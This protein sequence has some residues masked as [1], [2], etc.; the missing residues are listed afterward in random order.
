MVHSP[1]LLV[2]GSGDEQSQMTETKQTV[3]YPDPPALAASR[4]ILDEKMEKW[5]RAS[6][7]RGRE[8]EEASSEC[9]RIAQ[10]EGLHGTE[11]DPPEALPAMRA[12]RLWAQNR[13]EPA[14]TLEARSRHAR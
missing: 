8:H 5:D 2:T 14:S 10:R 3:D 13:Q 6:E 12:A 11:L 4:D 7:C 1:Q 9:V